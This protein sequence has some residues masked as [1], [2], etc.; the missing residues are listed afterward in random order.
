MVCEKCGAEISEGVAI[1][2]ACSGK[3]DVSTQTGA[4]VD[5]HI[6]RLAL[7]SMIL[8]VSL[9]FVI[10]CLFIIAPGDSSLEGPFAFIFYV[11][12][13]AHPVALILGI[14]SLMRIADSR[15]TLSGRG[16]ARI[17]VALPCI[18]FILGIL[19][20]MF[21]R[22]RSKPHRMT[23]GTNLSG[24][25][26]AMLIYANDYD[27]KLPQAGA[28]ANTWDYMIPDWASGTRELA[29]GYEGNNSYGSV[30]ITSN[31]YLL[32]KYFDTGRRSEKQIRQIGCR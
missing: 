27:G 16:Y 1:C 7:A 20:P 32:V 30:T 23:C 26:K 17:G 21:A 6:S 8:S 11:I 2:E 10:L 9:V 15:G 31:F 13:F 29:F 5:I 28:R 22:T 3:G 24:L 14:V 19:M 25:G 18:L 4:P 12:F